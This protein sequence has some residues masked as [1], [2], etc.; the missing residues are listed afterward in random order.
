LTQR[1]RQKQWRLPESIA[2]AARTVILITLIVT[3]DQRNGDPSSMGLE[4][5][6]SRAISKIHEQ[7]IANAYND[8]TSIKEPDESCCSRTAESDL[9]PHLARGAGQNENVRAI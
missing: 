3:D 7:R 2:Q 6:I 8:E 4:F 1:G 9:Q 5:E